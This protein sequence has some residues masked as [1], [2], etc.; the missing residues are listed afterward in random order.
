[1]AERNKSTQAIILSVKESPKNNRNVCLL[2]PDKGIFFSTLYGGSKSK[3][4][5]LIQPFNIGTIYI[6]E[7]EAKNLIK[8][9]DFDPQNFHLTFRTSI[10]KNLAANLAE[11]IVIKTKCGGEAKSAFVLLKAFLDGIDAF[12]ESQTEPGLLRFIWRYLGLLGIQA[13]TSSCGDCGKTFEGKVFLNP[14]LNNFLC[15]SCGAKKKLQS[16]CTNAAAIEYLR[17]INNKSPSESRKMLLDKETEKSLK[18]IL[19]HL[20]QEATGSKL[21]SIEFFFSL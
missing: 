9:S 14:N 8:I 5:S 7:D 13:E 2:S 6:Y 12:D 11:E 15:Y 16:F 18:Y 20:I 17:A 4:K 10:I 3:L 19:F 1:M 21:N